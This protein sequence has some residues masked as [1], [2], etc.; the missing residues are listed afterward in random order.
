MATKTGALRGIVP[1]YRALNRQAENMAASSKRYRGVPE[2]F[3]DPLLS[4]YST[5]NDAVA[6]EENSVVCFN[7]PEMRNHRIAGRSY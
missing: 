6:P 4:L 2:G 5:G 3:A 1:V 7:S